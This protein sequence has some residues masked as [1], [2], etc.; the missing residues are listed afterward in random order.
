[1]QGW[2]HLPNAKHID[3]ILASLKANP[4]KWNAAYNRSSAW[5]AAWDG[6]L[7]EAQR[8]VCDKNRSS[9]WNAAR[10]SAWI[11]AWNE[12]WEAAREWNAASDDVWEAEA[13]FGSIAAL[14][15]Y[16]DCVKYLTMTP[17]ELRVWGALSG[18]PACIL[19][20]PTAIVLHEEATVCV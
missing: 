13:A 19:L 6:A 14:I 3:W 15:A 2:S 20:L 5:V 1:M 9:A 16:V 8:A 17:D 10:D 11:A 12:V 18:D 4:A 7:C